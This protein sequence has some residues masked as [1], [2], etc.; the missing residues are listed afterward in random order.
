MPGVLYVC[1]TP[2]GNLGDVTGRLAEVL[3]TVDVV[4]AEDTRRTGKLL[5]HL[6]VTVPLRS[7]F[8]GNE[9]TRS[10]ELGDRIAA[11]SS[12]ALVSDA[13][14][15]AIA[16]PGLSAVAATIAAGGTVVPIPGPSAVTAL[17]S[18]SGLPSER[19]V[20]EGFLPKKGT[21]RADRFASLAAEAR[22]VVFFTTAP[23]IVADL[24]LLLDTGAD[25]ARPVV[26]GRELTKLHEQIWRGS[27]AEAATAPFE[28]RG[29]F[30]VAV[31]GEVADAPDLD[32]AVAEARA[33]IEGG[34][35]VKDAAGELSAETGL[36]R[37]DLYERLIRRD[38]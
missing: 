21:A 13:G 20:F 1:S 34:K 8:A 35:S 5:A 11:G 29:E 15:P 4:Y 6:H 9:D 22:T 23:R 17:L 28:L 25:P 2:I 24:D 14:T 31:G 26:V 19:F 38:D 16:D 12:V 18:A 30:T 37:R 36:S 33:R 3:R 32:S 27:L 10:S 7:Y